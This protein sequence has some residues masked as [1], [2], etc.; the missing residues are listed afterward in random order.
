MSGDHQTGRPRH[1]K[2]LVLDLDETLVHATTGDLGRAPACTLCESRIPLRPQVHDFLDRVIDRFDEVAIWTASTRPYA[3]PLVDQL[4]G[5][6]DRFAFLWCRERCTYHCDFETRDYSWLKDIKKL[7]RRGHDVRH[8]LVVDDTPAKLRRS[9]GNHVWIRPFEGD[10]A[11]REL[12]ALAE[13]LDELGSVPNVRTV[14]K[15]GWRR[16]FG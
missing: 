6:L 10:P 13:Y 11:D 5:G 1:D 8:I 2:L 14:E 12:P 7:K 9:Y 15:R 16:R 3:A 4:L